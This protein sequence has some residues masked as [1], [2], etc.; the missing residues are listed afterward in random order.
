M[1]PEKSNLRGF[2]ITDLVITQT[3]I[4]LGTNESVCRYVYEIWTKDSELIT[5]IDYEDSGYSVIASIYSG[6]HEK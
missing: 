6:G 4:G 1:N 5:T 3:V 2:R